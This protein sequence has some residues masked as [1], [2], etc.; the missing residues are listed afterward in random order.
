MKLGCRVHG[1][2]FLFSITATSL[3]AGSPI[4]P[5]TKQTVTE[6]GYYQ[7]NYFEFSFSFPTSWTVVEKTSLNQFQAAGGDVL[8]NEGILKPNVVKADQ[9]NTTNLLKIENRRDS[10]TGYVP[11]I[12]IVAERLHDGAPFKNAEGYV[13]HT[14]NLLLRIHSP[15][16]SVVTPTSKVLVGGKEFFR[17]GIKSD[18]PEQTV[19]QFFYGSLIK[20]FAVSITV[21]AGDIDQLK[22][23]DRVLA[24]LRFA[25]P[26]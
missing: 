14:A 4:A 17:I 10:S 25:D 6:A 8:K 5:S 12:V 22:R 13:A 15:K 20:G 26:K 18:V 24:E 1:L 2:L 16:Y 9:Q 3:R 21:S 11:S 19:Q 7:D 23:T